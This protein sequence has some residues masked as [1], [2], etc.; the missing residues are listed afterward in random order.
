MLVLSIKKNLR[1]KMNIKHVNNVIMNCHKIS[2][3][4][5]VHNIDSFSLKSNQF[6]PLSGAKK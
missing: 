5:D 3:G 1:V 2:G 4:G 6:T